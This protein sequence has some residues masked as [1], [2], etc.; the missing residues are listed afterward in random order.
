MGGEIGSVGVREAVSAIPWLKLPI[1]T[2]AG[3][4]GPARILCIFFRAGG[5]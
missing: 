1:N 3:T 4:P 2:R 5:Q